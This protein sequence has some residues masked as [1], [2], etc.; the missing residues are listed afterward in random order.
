MNRRMAKIGS[1]GLRMHAWRKA[2][3]IGVQNPAAASNDEAK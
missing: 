2:K 3:A 1:M